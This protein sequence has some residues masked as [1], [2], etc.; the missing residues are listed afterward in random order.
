MSGSRRLL[1]RLV[2][3]PRDSARLTLLA[4]RLV[5]LLPLRDRPPAP[6]PPAPGGGARW[7][8]EL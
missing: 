7:R 3:L 6:G 2:R 5:M 4:A 1:A 8:R